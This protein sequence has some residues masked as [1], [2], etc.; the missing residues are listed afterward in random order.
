MESRTMGNGLQFLDIILFALIAVFLILRLRNVL[1][2]KGGHE[3]GYKDP[4]SARSEL[5]KPENN[6]EDNVVQLPDQ[7]VS[8]GEEE[9]LLQA[10]EDTAKGQPKGKADASPA[11]VLAS[12]LAQIKAADPAFDSD[13][14]L[15]G[16]RMAFDLILGA[17]AA[18]E[19]RTLRPL[20]SDEVFGNFSQAIRSREQAGETMDDTLIGIKKAEIAEAYME[21][22]TALVTVKFVSEQ[23]NV[24]RDENGDV[25]DGDPSAI[26]EVTDF[27]TFARDTRSPDPNWTLVATRSLE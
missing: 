25:I 13:D 7:T 1:G 26:A 10:A 14:F 21:G 23:I 4:F 11:D 6:L 19:T 3:G 24:F 17:Y 16:S 8:S 22:H 18:G 5:E 2:R 27:W 12:G 20:L 15:S 9:A